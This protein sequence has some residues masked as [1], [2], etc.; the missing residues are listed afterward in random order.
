MMMCEGRNNE[1]CSTRVF[2]FTRFCNK[3]YYF[4]IK[5]ALDYALEA[6]REEVEGLIVIYQSL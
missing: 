1:K 2:A 6:C 4:F 3:N 5:K